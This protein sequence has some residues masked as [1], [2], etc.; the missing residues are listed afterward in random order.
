MKIQGRWNQLYT[1]IASE[2]LSFTK[3]D[4]FLQRNDNYSIY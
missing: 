1:F 4:F 2:Q 3:H